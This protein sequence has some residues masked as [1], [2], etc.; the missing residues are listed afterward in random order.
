[1]GGSLIQLNGSQVT[2]VIRWVASSGLGLPCLSALSP[3]IAGRAHPSGGGM[4][5]LLGDRPRSSEAVAP[6]QDRKQ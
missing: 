3:G 1:M 2:P 6:G 4:L 5:A